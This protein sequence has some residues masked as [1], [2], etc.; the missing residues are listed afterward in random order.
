[1]RKIAKILALVINISLAAC[2]SS[3]VK[4]DQ[5]KV[6]ALQKGKTTYAEARRNFGNPTSDTILPDGTRM[7]MYSYVGVQSHPENFIP[8][9]GAF[10]GGADSEHTMVMLNFDQNGILK[11]Y[12]ASQGSSGSGHNLESLSQPRQ[13]VRAVE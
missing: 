1:V 6:E 11:N 5:S 9:V 13:D 10:V 3:G 8:I 7:V 12:T 2:V 4:I